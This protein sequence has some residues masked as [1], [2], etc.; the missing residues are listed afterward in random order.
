MANPGDFAY[1]LKQQADI[2]RV[3]GDYV[4]L[5]KAG[6]Q[7][8]SG[9]CPF[10]NEKT[11]SFSVHATRQFFHC[12]GCG[13]SGDVF[14]FV[15]K[16]EN[17]TFPEAVRA[18][19]QKLGVALPKVSYSSPAEAKE[20][21]QRTVLLDIHEHACDFFQECLRRPEGARAREYLAGRGLNEEMIKAFRIAYAPDSG[22]LLRDRL[23]AEFDEDVLRESGLFSWKDKEGSQPTPASPHREGPKDQRPTTNDESPASGQ[24]PTTL[25]SKFRNRVMFPIT[26]ESG[27][28]IAFTGRTLSTDEKAGPKYL[29]SP[30]TAIYSKSRVLF[31]LDRAKEAIRKLDYAI[32]VE[33]QMDCISV[34]A[35]G[36]HNVIASSGTAFTELQARLLG[37]FSKNVVVNFDP[38]TAGAKATERTLGLL[39]EEEFQIKVLSL[40]PG[41]D[42]D[43]YIRR[44]GKDAYA[45]AL[46]NSQPYFDYLIE[47]ARAQ[48]SARTPESKVK[49]V[50]F[51]LPHIQRVPSRIVRDE[52]A[53]EI[54][55]KLAIDSA[56]LRQELQHA[57]TKRAAHEIKTSLESQVTD[58]EKILIRALT[59]SH[60]VQAGENRLSSRE[61]ADEDFD[62][63][64][65]AEYALRNEDLHRGM[66]TEGLMDALLAAPDSAD[67]VSLPVTDADRN[68]LASVLMKDDEELTPERLE[69]AVR[70]LRRI[71]LRRKL[72]Q[73]QR[74]LQAKP[75]QEASRLQTLL[76]EKLRLKRA[77]MDPGL[78]GE[79]SPPA[80]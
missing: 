20:A 68:L 2:V 26:N 5:K 41:F 78:P 11:P 58:A 70:G 47:R 57:A 42:P 60:E 9:L 33:G 52:L 3:I 76:Q 31:N 38:D 1:E 28:V 32:L 35:S 43:L 77:L 4:K 75:N 50:N 56:V 54:A 45:Q 63:A 13:S 44:K 80:A 39:V 37:R 27:R 67:L 16:I 74:E 48:F 64:R 7:N 79:E 72:E 6:A 36:F 71:H 29:N 55:Q 61:G 21:K 69:G 19:A 65:Q 18:V 73:V 8:Y 12:F 15:Q 66:A 49:A 24:Q 10:H 22:F 34:Y 17:I 46:R 51:L 23:R 62:P 25:Y 59:S 53:R 14:S 30:E 40:E